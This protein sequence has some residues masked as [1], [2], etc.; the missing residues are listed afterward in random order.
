LI[1]AQ[2]AILCQIAEESYEEKTIPTPYEAW[3]KIRKDQS[4]FIRQT[5]SRR[6][7]D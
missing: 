6:R 2:D 4:P 1:V 3:R 7:S 5:A